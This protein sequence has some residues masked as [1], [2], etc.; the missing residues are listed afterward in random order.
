MDLAFVCRECGATCELP[1][2]SLEDTHR[3]GCLEC[4]GRLMQAT[5]PDGTR[6]EVARAEGDAEEAMWRGHA[7]L[8]AGDLEGALAD[9]SRAVELDPLL[10]P[11]WLLRGS[12]R[13][14]QG[15]RDGATADLE[16]FLRLAPEHPQAERTRQK[17]IELR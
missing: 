15:D 17:L 16:Q 11:A 9:A 3:A 14:R 7:R 2:S 1:A 4:G 6:R 5:R 10:A 13:V 8:A 12:I